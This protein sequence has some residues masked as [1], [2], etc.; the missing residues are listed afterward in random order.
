MLSANIAFVAAQKSRIDETLTVPVI[1]R[2]VFT[3]I[4][5]HYKTCNETGSYTLK[6]TE[7]GMHDVILDEEYKPYQ[8]QL[9][10]LMKDLPMLITK[11]IDLKQEILQRVL[12]TPKGSKRKRCN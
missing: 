5:S 9:Q 10:A 12:R 3:L 7:E 1:V 11:V 8:E 2:E 6:T 4:D